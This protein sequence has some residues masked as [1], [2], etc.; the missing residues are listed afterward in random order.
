MP[1]KMADSVQID[2]PGIFISHAWEDKALVK[3]LE[4]ELKVAGTE[5]WVDYTAI[6]GGD[7]LPERMS[8][9]L[10][11]LQQNTVRP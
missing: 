4:T 3:R 9:A 2:K 8:N 7:N 10:E 11:L 1:A 6:R 5:V